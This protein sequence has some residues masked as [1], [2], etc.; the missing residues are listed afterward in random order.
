M[1]KIIVIFLFLLLPV[2]ALA[3]TA[4]L[5]EAR[6]TKLFEFQKTPVWCWAACIEMCLKYYGFNISQS[7]IVQRTFGS[8]IPT[9]GN[10]IQVTE[11]L[12]YMGTDKDGKRVLISASVFMGSPT[13]EAIVNH[14]KQKK[15]IIMAF[16]NPGTFVGHAILV[17]GVEYEIIIGRVIIRNVTVRDPFPYSPQH[18]QGGGRM[19]IPNTVNPTNIWL[20]DATEEN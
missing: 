5:D 3:K 7:E 16:H 14:L 19:V 17:T 18:I 1:K 6:M 8:V 12:N 13:A 15:P 20:I 9:T 11:N 2:S 10:W 4:S